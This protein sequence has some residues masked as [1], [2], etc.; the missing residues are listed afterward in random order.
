VSSKIEKDNAL[1]AANL[2]PSI[3]AGP[4]GL[5]P[6]EAAINH[7]SIAESGEA[8]NP[9]QQEVQDILKDLDVSLR[10]N[11]SE[12]DEQM[13]SDEGRSQRRDLAMAKQELSELDLFDEE[14]YEEVKIQKEIEQAEKRAI[15]V[16]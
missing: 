10:K 13:L 2:S 12:L 11:L 8:K 7:F 15:L 9:F 14:A 3:F 6:K 16:C 4:K 1:T 5:S